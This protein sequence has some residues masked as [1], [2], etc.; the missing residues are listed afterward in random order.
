MT[1][2]QLKQSGFRLFYD[3]AKLK[4]NFPIPEAACVYDDCNQVIGRRL[5]LNWNLDGRDDC[6]SRLH[7][8]MRVSLKV[9]QYVGNTDISQLAI[10]AISGLPKLGNNSRAVSYF[11]GIPR[12]GVETRIVQT[13]EDLADICNV[14]Y[15]KTG[16]E[17]FERFRLTPDDCLYTPALGYKLVIAAHDS[18]SAGDVAT[19]LTAMGGLFLPVIA[20]SVGCDDLNNQINNIWA[21]LAQNPLDLALGVFAD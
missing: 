12:N 18:L 9:T 7:T 2:V 19:N 14:I 3:T 16:T 13:I 10:D 15:G 11:Q 6:F 5:T 4:A 8:I 21:P 20:D 17:L 1:A